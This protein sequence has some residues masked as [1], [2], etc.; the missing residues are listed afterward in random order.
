MGKDKEIRK[1]TIGGQGVL[2]GVMMRSPI[3]SGLAVR[4][5]TGEIVTKE[6]DN[7]KR[8]GSLAKIPIVR[9]VVA[10]IESLVTGMKLTSQSAEM[11]GEGNAETLVGKAI[12]PFT[13][14]DL[15]LI[16]KVYPWN[17]S[18]DEL[19]K[20]LDRSLARLGTDYLD[21]Y[22]MHWPNPIQFRGIWEEAMVETW[23]A[24]EELYHEG[25]IRAIGVSNFHPKHIETLMKY[26]S[27]KPMVDQL[28]LC[29]GVTQP[30]VVDYCRREGIITEAYSPFGT[31]DIFQN[32]DLQCIAEKYHKTVGQVVLRWCISQEY[33]PLPKSSHADRIAQNLDIFDFSL[34]E[35]DLELISKLDCGQTAP[36]PDRIPF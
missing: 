26:A 1:C 2:E 27:I 25:K 20:A 34:N 9:G 12:Q 18:A 29:P 23:R 31:G 6:W 5:A 21:L 11:Y 36:D 35:E 10:F 14:G 15:Y 17:A 3:H 16:S 19:P 32:K 7:K 13:R 30:E 8:P 24:F 22:L 4:R 28:K 33:I